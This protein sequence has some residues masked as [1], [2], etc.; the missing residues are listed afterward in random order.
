MN[1]PVKYCL[2]GFSL[3]AGGFAGF[4]SLMGDRRN[5]Q[6]FH[7]GP[8]DEV[9]K[10][11]ETLDGSL[12]PGFVAIVGTQPKPAL[13]GGGSTP[14]LL[15]SPIEQCCIQTQ[16]FIQKRMNG[17]PSLCIVFLEIHLNAH[18]QIYSMTY[19]TYNCEMLLSCI[20]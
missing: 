20:F 15:F 1:I 8:S 18:L 11:E 14:A 7:F 2:A 19:C 17:C 9:K 6:M 13:L 5:A 16:C 3:C 4:A 12:I 10:K